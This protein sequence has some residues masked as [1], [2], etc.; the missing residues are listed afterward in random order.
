LRRDKRAAKPRRCW[1]FGVVVRRDAA[2]FAVAAKGAKTTSEAAK[3]ATKDLVDLTEHRGAAH[4]LNRHRA[5][6]GI[7]GKTEF[8]AGWSDK[9]ILHHVSDVATDPRSTTGVGKW[10]S[11]YAIG[12]RDGVTIRVD[13]YPPNHPNYAG[14]ISTAYPINVAPN[15]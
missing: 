4:I 11:P 5:G 7:S 15:P 8:P 3:G 10:N 6:T 13:F 12:T 9:K 2:A 14:K 1:G